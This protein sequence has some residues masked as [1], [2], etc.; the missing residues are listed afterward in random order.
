MSSAPF[1]LTI[2]NS[3]SAGISL[4]KNDTGSTMHINNKGD[5][6]I[7]TD[8]PFGE[9]QPCWGLFGKIEL[10]Q[11]SYLIVI[12]RA[13]KAGSIV[14]APVIQVKS[15]LFLRLKDASTNISTKD[16]QYVDMIQSL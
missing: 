9:T 16:K 4:C 12:Q 1:T 14:G 10:L 8:R 6:S 11:D 13:E 3:A 2:G 5:A 15:L 7:S